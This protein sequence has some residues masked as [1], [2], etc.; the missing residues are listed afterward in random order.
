MI[1]QMKEEIKQY[2]GKKKLIYTSYSPNTRKKD[3]NFNLKLLF[4]PLKWKRGEAENNI[5]N[6]FKK[7]YP[8]SKVFV[9]NYA[10]SA[11]YH[12]F[13]NQKLNTSNE[14]I[15]QGFTCSAAILPAIWNGLIPRYCDINPQTLSLDEEKLKS[16]LTPHTKYIIAQHT[17]GL[18]PDMELLRKLAD[19]NGSI[20]IEDCTHFIPTKEDNKYG[21]YGDIAIF[22]FGRDKVISGVDGGVLVVNNTA[23]L[24]SIPDNFEKLP[25]PSNKWTLQR[26]LFPILWWIIKKTYFSGFG[27][28]VHLISMSLGILT[29]ATTPEE[30][31]GEKPDSI[32]A[33]L[34][35]ALALIAEKQIDDL[36]EIQAHRRK[37]RDKYKSL[38]SKIEC[39]E[40]ENYT[41]TPLRVSILVNDRDKI[42]KYCI[43]RGVNLGD[44]YS[45]PISPAQ[46]DQTKLGYSKGQCPVAE[47]I[48]E[49]ILN[50]PVHINMTERDCELVIDTIAEAQEYFK[51]TEAISSM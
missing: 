14:V 19:E 1:F 13:K 28:L 43:E 21:K 36:D 6:Y 46:V 51:N 16:M 17:L 4:S 47:S 45:Q 12:F 48:C 39:E 40:F 20:L 2:T 22:S 49:R 32:P 9:F 18:S 34:P 35:N 5:V 44:W 29:K 11:L 24:N 41:H 38:Y 25:Y 15:C 31:K 23:L 10:R 27:K 30:K 3:L 37:M 8:T 50:L 33:K 26:I 42:L 7:F